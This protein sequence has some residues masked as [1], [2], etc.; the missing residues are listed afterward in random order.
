MSIY[1]NNQRVR[2]QWQRDG[3]RPKERPVTSLKMDVYH[4]WTLGFFFM[5]LNENIYT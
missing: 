3:A 1:R 2:I 4:Q 5:I